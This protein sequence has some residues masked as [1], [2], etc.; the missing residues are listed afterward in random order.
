RWYEYTGKTIEELR[1]W[2]WQSV[3]DPGMLPLVLERW[4][5]SIA[6]GTPFE[7]KFPLRG[8]DDKFRWFLTR[9]NPMRDDSG[10]LIRWVGVN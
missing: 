2:G 5:A 1:G 6:S 10:R 7:M 4:N 3:H 9:I 8:K